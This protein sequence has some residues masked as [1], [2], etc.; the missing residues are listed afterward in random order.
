MRHFSNGGIL[1]ETIEE[2]LDLERKLPTIIDNLF[3][4]F[5]TSSGDPKKDS[6][7]PWMHCNP[8]G[9]GFTWD[10]ESNSYYIPAG[11]IGITDKDKNLPG[12]KIIAFLKLLFSRTRN[13]TNHNIKYD[14]HV[15]D[16]C[17]RI[18]ILD[19]EIEIRCTLTLAKLVDS[20]RFHYDLEILSQDYCYEDISGFK[21][22]FDAYLKTPVGKWRCKDFGIVPIDFMAVYACQDVLTNR[23]LYYLLLDDL[24]SEEVWETE[25]QLTRILFEIEKTGFKL[26]AEKAILHHYRDHPTK[27]VDLRQKIHDVTGR[28]ISPNKN[29]DCFDLLCNQYNLPVI[30]WTDGGVNSQSEPSFGKE[31]LKA[32]KALDG[33]PEEVKQVIDWMEEYKQVFKLDTSFTLPYLDLFTSV[34]GRLHPDFN[35]CVRTGRMACRRPN[36]Q[37]LPDEAKEYI[38]PDKDHL[39]Y[40]YD[41]KQIEYRG[42]AHFIKNPKLLKAYQED[43]EVDYHTTMATL[44]NIER[45]PAKTMNFGVSFGAGKTKTKQML[46]KALDLSKVPAGMSFEEYCDTRGEEIYNTYHATL[47]EL[48]AT[49][50][51]ASAVLRDRGYVKNLFGRVRRMQRRFH[52]KAFNTVIQSTAADIMKLMTLRIHARLQNTGAN[53]LGMVHD[54]WVISI[55]KEEAAELEVIIKQ[56]IEETDCRMDV[57]VYC[58]FKK[59]ELNW[60]EAA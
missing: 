21:K 58:S 14:A 1:I 54:S 11:H 55:P 31:A 22:E 50:Y 43:P 56:E 52:Y 23:K 39:L 12:Y 38:I 34:D 51:R 28:V 40:D 26:D 36:M 37:Q 49:S 6:T 48:K 19:Y 13:W 7:N 57:P 47:P 17:Y 25:K 32:Y 4:D 59:S 18:S 29:A 30:E 27:M 45:D 3:L 9:I 8:L 44:C 24:M 41:L 20:D 60:R 15:L 2:L 10:S 46:K 53:L 5:E 33:I 42:I 35:Q 16:N